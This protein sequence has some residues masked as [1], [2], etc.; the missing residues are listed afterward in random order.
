MLA[1]KHPQIAELARFERLLLTEFRS[2]SDD[3]FALMSAALAGDTFAQLCEQL[4]ESHSEEGVSWVA[5][6]YLSQWI[7][8]GLVSQLV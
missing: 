6:N 7:A 5:V 3:E 1:Y 2:I 8:Q 4:L